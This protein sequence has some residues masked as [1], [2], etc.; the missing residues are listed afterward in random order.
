LKKTTVYLD[1]GVVAAPKGISKHSAQNW[2]QLI[3]DSRKIKQTKA[4]PGADTNVDAARKA[5][6]AT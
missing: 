1:D 3:R 4:Y 6:R 2:A 5:A